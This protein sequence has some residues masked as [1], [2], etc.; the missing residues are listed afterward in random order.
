MVNI[1]D[2]LRQ[3]IERRSRRAWRDRRN[4]GTRRFH[5]ISNI[6][7]NT[8]SYRIPEPGNYYGSTLMTVTRQES[9]TITI[10]GPPPP[11]EPQITIAEILAKR[12]CGSWNRRKLERISGGNEA[13][14]IRQILRL[15]TN[16]LL[17]ASNKDW[18]WNQLVPQALK[19]RVTATG[20]RRLEQLD[21]LYGPME[22]EVPEPLPL[23]PPD[24][25]FEVTLE[26]VLDRSCR[27]WNRTRL[28]RVAG[29]NERLTIR[30]VLLLKPRA[31]RGDPTP[32]DKLWIWD[33]IVPQD[34][35][36]MVAE[37][38]PGNPITGSGEAKVDSIVFALN[39]C[40]EHQIA[41]G[42][43]PIEVPEPLPDPEEE[44]EAEEVATEQAP[45]R[46]TPKSERTE[47][48]EEAEGL[49]S[50]L[51]SFLRGKKD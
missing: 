30:Q 40:Y 22:A 21:E 27:E 12:P 38:S 9:G 16:R 11:P 51:F 2:D 31:S 20:D 37:R 28:L 47:L 34:F 25:E 24:P 10:E 14:S 23:P 49:V 29:G 32:A 19:D 36:D 44:A 18:V 48:I 39:E 15:P 26:Q 8:L 42:L 5:R 45:D 17:T 41:E 33:N 4:N 6:Q 1:T 7:A 50:K 35:K 13:L 3:K 46:E 43:T